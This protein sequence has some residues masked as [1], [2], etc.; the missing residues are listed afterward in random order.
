MEADAPESTQWEVY[1]AQGR[2][3][4]EGW[5]P[6]QLYVE[7]VLSAEQAELIDALL[8]T[9][10]TQPVADAGEQVRAWAA[11][12]LSSDN[13]RP[14]VHPR[15]SF[16]AYQWEGMMDFHAWV[17]SKITHGCF[18]WGKVVHLILVKSKLFYLCLLR[19]TCSNGAVWNETFF[20]HLLLY[21]FDF[22]SESSWRMPA[23]F[24][25]M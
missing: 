4:L 6:Q 25:M 13:R 3:V 22:F 20:L 16:P 17:G 11:S 7:G 2:I 23:T 18:Y 8:D 9:V 12:R 24:S 14:I 5:I 1:C 21:V 15:F 10:P 19:S